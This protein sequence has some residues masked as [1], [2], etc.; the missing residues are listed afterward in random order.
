MNVLILFG[1]TFWEHSKVNKALIE[2]IKNETNIKVQNLNTTY[3]N[4]QIDIEKEL[5]LLKNANK[6]IFQ[7]PL[8]WFSTPSI[9]KEWQ[10][11]ILTNILYSQNPKL[12]KDKYFQIITTAGGTKS[13]YDGHHGATINELLKPIYYSFEY[14]SLK[15]LEP[16]VIYSASVA[17]LAL[18]DYKQAVLSIN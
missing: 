15:S 10:D 3:P 11:R 9:L 17:N 7:F 12:L 13:S 1:H 4:G 6:I 18:N 14:S 5:D 8:F 2:S 16:F